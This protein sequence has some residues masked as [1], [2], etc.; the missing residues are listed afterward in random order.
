MFCVLNEC[1]QIVTWQF[2]HSVSFD[3]VRPILQRLKERFDR[4]S[5]KLNEFYIDNCCSWRKKIQ[6]VFGND[7]KVLL[8]LFHAIK[9]VGE[10][11]S[12]KHPLRKECMNALRMVFRDPTDLGKER[13][14]PTPTHEVLLQQLESFVQAWD[15]A[16]F[17]GSPVLNEACKREVRNIKKH[18][19]CGCLSGI[20]PGRGTNRNENLHKNLNSLMGSSRYGVELANALIATCLH[21]HNMKRSSTPSTP[22]TLHQCTSLSTESFG[23]AC[24]AQLSTVAAQEN[25]LNE[26]YIH[27]SGSELL[28]C[29]LH[30]LNT[31]VQLNCEEAGDDNEHHDDT[32]ENESTIN[33]D[34]LTIKT[35]IAQSILWYY[36]HVSVSRQSTTASMDVRHMPFMHMN[37]DQVIENC[38]TEAVQHNEVL[39]NTLAA[40]NFQQIQVDRDGN[41]LFVS[42]VTNLMLNGEHPSNK[43]LAA[44]HSTLP[45]P[46]NMMDV[47]KS[48]RTAIVNEW[49][50]ERTSQYQSFLTGHQLHEI[51]TNY[52][53]MGEFAGDVGDLILPALSN[54][55]RAPIVL[56]TNIEHL[57]IIVQ[58]PTI[59]LNVHTEP[60]YLTFDQVGAHYGVAIPILMETRDK[61]DETVTSTVT[62]N[63]GRKS[64]KGPS[65]AL[66]LSKYA[67]RCK[68][69]NSKTPCSYTCRCSGCKNPYG[70]KP[71]SKPITIN[72]RKRHHHPSQQF[73][74]KS[75]KTTHFMKDI[76][77]E[78]ITGIATDIEF[79]IVAAIIN[80]MSDSFERRDPYAHLDSIHQLYCTIVFVLQAMNIRGPINSRSKQ[81]IGKIIKQF[82]YILDIFMKVK[83]PSSKE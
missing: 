74:L 12:K 78:I 65:C 16:G 57:P 75:R 5:K 32:V 83:V 42:V 27:N 7:V 49:M 8:D 17:Q 21:K 10:K 40:W 71:I 73:P 24:T 69:F 70:T 4:Q 36:T 59:T 72:K 68:C 6:S 63:C 25:E 50:G 82:V 43:H 20:R 51:A 61:D 15:T 47:V 3:N 35:I 55:L 38:L 30:S 41:C 28:L 19:A 46:D 13:Q 22:V 29:R 58:Y 64:S 56:F 44:I 1:G 11:I 23:L 18:I 14:K 66:E 2:A 77:E 26:L 62:C 34:T 67:T 54:V 33:I 45:T 48:L 80:S 76:G 53:S 31:A 81:E 39:E 9:R 60:I 79:L 52:L 37:T